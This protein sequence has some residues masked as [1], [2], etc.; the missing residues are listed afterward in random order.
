MFAGF[1]CRMARLSGWKAR[2]IDA[3]YSAPL[4]YTT[5]QEDPNLK[6]IENKLLYLLSM[7]FFWKQIVS[8][9]GVS[10]MTIIYRRRQE[11][12]IPSRGGRAI[13]DIQLREHLHQLQQDLPSLGQTLV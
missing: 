7:S 1:T 9:L 13:S 4:I 8:I 5:S 6:S 2:Y 12:E 3:S 10:Y 11:Y